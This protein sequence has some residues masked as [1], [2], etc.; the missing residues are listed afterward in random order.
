MSLEAKEVPGILFA[1]QGA[2]SAAYP[3]IIDCLTKTHEPNIW[4]IF[5]VVT[6]KHWWRQG[7]IAMMCVCGIENSKSEIS[8]RYSKSVEAG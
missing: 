4:M 8:E 5:T 7:V 6:I 2:Q 3:M 1:G